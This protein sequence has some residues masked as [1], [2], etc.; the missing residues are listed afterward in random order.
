VPFAGRR[1]QVVEP[2]EL[3]GAQLD[4]VRCRVLVDTRDA[5]GAE[6]RRDIVALGQ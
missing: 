1:G 6:D 2:F 3:L 5:P 4:R